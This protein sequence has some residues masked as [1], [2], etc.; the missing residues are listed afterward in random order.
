MTTYRTTNPQGTTEY[1][2]YAHAYLY[3]KDVKQAEALV[4][5]HGP[6]ALSCLIWSAMVVIVAGCVFLACAP[7]LIAHAFGL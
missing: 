2:R 1:Q 6:S 4:R 7:E 3:P 5:Q